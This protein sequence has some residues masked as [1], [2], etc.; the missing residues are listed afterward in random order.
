MNH[1]LLTFITFS[2]LTVVIF[3]FFWLRVQPIEPKLIETDTTITEI[4]EPSITFVNPTRGTDT[5]TLRIIEFGDFECGP[6]STMAST[7]EAVL[8]ANPDTIQ[9]VWKDLPNESLHQFATPAAIAAHCADRQG[10]FWQY[11]DELFARQSYLS[12]SQFPQIATDI[13]L[14]VGKLTSCF[15]TRDTL[16]IVKRD[17]NEAIGLG[18]TSTPTIFIG[19][20]ILI[21][22]VST[23]TILDTVQSELDRLSQ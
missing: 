18:L 13:G 14:D 17:Y 7:L 8:I 1:R 23:Q 3:I 12:E 16:P 15:D 5:P 6:C 22:A 20:E 9:L 19:D 21:G 10:A 11:H 4:S 2:F